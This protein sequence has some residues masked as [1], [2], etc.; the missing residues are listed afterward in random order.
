[1]SAVP[2]ALVAGALAG[3]GIA[4]PVGAIGA[5]LVALAARTSFRIGACAAL[6][7]ATADGVY[8]LV[9]AL[10]GSALGRVL[11]PVLAPLKWVSA[12]VLLVMAVR[13]AVNAIRQFRGHQAGR[14]A[15]ENVPDS[16]SR[17]YLGL[18]GVTMLNPLTVVYFAALVLGGRAAAAPPGVPDQVA[19]VAAAFVASASWQLVLA[20]SGALLGRVLTGPRGRCATG[21]ASSIL[22]AA[23]AI[24]MLA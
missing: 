1:M 18:W 7:V 22:I 9:A 24:R 23:L 4:V 8:A 17:A 6:G 15:R 12:A 19:F 2:A 20:S 5:Y 21:L 3:Y 11:Q 14:P 13:G 16:A 10:G